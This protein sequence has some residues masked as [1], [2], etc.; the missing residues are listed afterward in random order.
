MLR[1]DLE[2]VGVHTTL[3]SNRCSRATAAEAASKQRESVM[4]TADCQHAELLTADETI[5]S[6][7]EA[8]KGLHSA[9]K[10][11]ASQ[12]RKPYLSYMTA[13]S[14]SYDRCHTVSGRK[15]HTAR[16]EMPYC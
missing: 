7:I 1:E 2:L 4:K 14:M 10:G 6:R 11:E 8:N 15:C 9:D 13:S 5:P 12:L 16:E 3:S